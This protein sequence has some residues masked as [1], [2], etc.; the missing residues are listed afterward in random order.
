MCKKTLSPTICPNT[1][2]EWNF[3]WTSEFVGGHDQRMS[4]SLSISQTISNQ[5]IRSKTLDSYLIAE[6][7]SPQFS[8]C[9]SLL[10]LRQHM[11]REGS[12]VDY[13]VVSWSS[14]DLPLQ[15]WDQRV[16]GRW[17]GY[18]ILWLVLPWF[19][20]SLTRDLYSSPV[21][22]TYCYMVLKM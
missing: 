9:L 4:P 8:T 18:S 16:A 19:A 20:T 14:A 5:K 11:G 22:V 3:D 21:S 17:Q 7:L 2:L 15:A 12:P 6:I 1:P 13:F 10:I